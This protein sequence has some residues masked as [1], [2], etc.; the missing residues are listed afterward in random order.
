MAGA[1][2]EGPAEFLW[3]TSRS[4][5]RTKKVCSAACMRPS[6]ATPLLDN[7]EILNFRYPARTLGVIRPDDAKCPDNGSSFFNQEKIL[8]T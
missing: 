1:A 2:Q 8:L 3:Y 5:A 4:L 6:G 7:E